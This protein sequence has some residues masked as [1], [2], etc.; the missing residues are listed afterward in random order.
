MSSY[1][2]HEFVLL[3]GTLSEA[4]QEE[5]RAI[6]SRATI[7]PTGFA[8]TYHY[9]DLRADPHAL[10]AKHFDLRVYVASHGIKAFAMRLPRALF[11][12]A[13]AK[14]FLIEEALSV[15][16]VGDHVLVTFELNDEGGGG[17]WIDDVRAEKLLRALTPLRAQV[18]RGDLRALYLG[19]LAAVTAYEPEEEEGEVVEPPVPPGLGALDKAL[20]TL[21]EFLELDPDALEAA[22][23]TSPEALTPD[24]DAAILSSWL[25]EQP[26]ARC[27]AWLLRVAHGEGGRV[28]A[29]IHKACRDD[30]SGPGAVVAPR[31]TVAAL[32][33]RKEELAE[34][35]H[36]RERDAEARALRK[37]LDEL[38]T[39]KE[40][41]WKRAEEQVELGTS[42]SY[43]QAVVILRDLRELAQHEGQRAAFEDRIDALRARFRTRRSL[44]ER[45]DK[46]KLG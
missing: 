2:Y 4:A 19:W 6:S 30:R 1:Q 34:A 42:R 14:P 16:E 7:T 17:E 40:E 5:L 3:D 22:A 45:L 13:L 35:R 11:D 43:E 27:D 36:Q 15:E 44:L 23:E 46:A 38:S 12:P 20:K 41:M 32:W 33:A 21:A 29:E 37:R 9:G 8:N 10:L 28:G 18:L 24:D 31:R 26:R 39:K 25:A